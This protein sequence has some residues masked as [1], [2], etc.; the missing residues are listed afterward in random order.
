MVKVLAALGGGG[1]EE[2]LLETNGAV[3]GQEVGIG[4]RGNTSLVPGPVRL[5]LDSL[6]AHPAGQ[7]AVMA[8]RLFGGFS[9][10]ADLRSGP[11]IATAGA[12]PSLARVE[13]PHAPGRIGERAGRRVRLPPDVRSQL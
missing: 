3:R 9:G 12:R 11:R 4:F 10:S 13:T 8:I 1:S 6:L 5:C 2:T 7:R